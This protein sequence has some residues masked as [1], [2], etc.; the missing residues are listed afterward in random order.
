VPVKIKIVAERY[1]TVDRS[2]RPSPSPLQL[3]TTT[4]LVCAY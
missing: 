4:W 3:K 1:A 2:A